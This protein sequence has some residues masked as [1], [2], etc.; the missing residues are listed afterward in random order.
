MDRTAL[1]AL[2]VEADDSERAALLGRHDEAIECGLRAR[3]VF[4]AHGDVLAAGKIE[5]N[6]GNIYFRR[7]DYHEAERF[8]RAARE[9]FVVVNDQKE[10]AKVENN[11]AN[12]LNF[13]YK[14]R[15]AAPLYEQALLNAE[16]AGLEV[17]QGEIEC[18][19]GNL[20]LFQ[21]RYDRALDY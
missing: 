13:Q 7:D 5:Q 11:L 2:L 18:N 6:L 12:A 8:Y 9:R 19:L 10:L 17:T 20:A 4:L 15:L 21:G 3:D 14:F 16:A 1:V